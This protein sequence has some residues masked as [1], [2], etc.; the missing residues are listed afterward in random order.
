M[1]AN[2][3]PLEGN[4]V[5][6]EVELEEQE[7]A[8]A[9]DA[10]FKKIAHQVNIPGFRPG[11]AP[12]RLVEARVGIEAARA[13][14]LNDSVP[15]FYMQALQE[16][17]VDAIT[18]PELKITSGEEEGPVTFEAEVEIR[19]VPTIPGYQ[20]LQVT[21][22]SPEPSDEEV[23]DQIE[24]MR[25]RYGELESV[26]RPA[27]NGD[28]VT[29]DISGELEGEAVPGLTATDYSY[30]VGGGMQSLGPDFDTQIA[31]S[32]A[33]DIL[34]F[35]S[36]VPPNDDEV[37]FH[38]EIKEVNERQLPD[39]TDDW[40]NEASEF[41]TVAELRADIAG[42]M[43]E[44]RKT[45]IVNAVRANALEALAELVDD[46]IPD[47]LVESEMTRQLRQLQYRFQSQGLELGQVLAMSGQSEE[48]F[49]AQLREGAIDAVRVDLALRS[50]A[51][52]EGIVETEEEVDAEVEALAK[53]FGQKAGRVRRDLER[54]EQMPAVRSDIRKAKA[55]T[56]LVEHVEIVDSEG[57]VIDRASLPSLGET[58]SH[59][60]SDH[61]HGDEGETTA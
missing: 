4:K 37:T 19:P 60:H 8:S 50:L 40:A 23:D 54:A 59:D 44:V 52:K 11:K 43:A 28:F 35:T 20:G 41:E 61:D 56:W 10:A 29:V 42:R 21:V 45:E 22:P 18:A 38:V 46:E 14:A 30:E 17:N 12:R 25:A 57:K 58:D 16:T 32:K 24:R 27:Q 49:V 51:T 15:E 6:L 53:Q 31:G 48:E 13:Q 33:G 9:I 34:D 5:K 36:P 47:A 39:L 7:V 1:Q 55:V 2:V 3:E 26:E